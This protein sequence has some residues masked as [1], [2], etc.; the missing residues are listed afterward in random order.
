MKLAP[1]SAACDRMAACTSVLPA[2]KALDLDSDAVAGEVAGHIGAGDLAALVAL[3]GDDQD[4]DVLGAREERHRVG[5]GARRRPAAVPAGHDA[6]E[7]EAL[8]LDMRHDDD[9]AAGAEQRA[10]DQQFLRGAALALRLADDREVEAPRDAA[11]QVGGAG[12]AGI[13]DAG[14]GGHRSAVLTAASKRAIAALALLVFSSR[15]TSIRSVG[16]PPSTLPG[17]IGS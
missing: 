15:W 13:E 8:L 17:M 10:F 2:G 6:V 3:A 1:T 11:E 12:D 5:D 9:R 16:T 7:H 4:F 14:F